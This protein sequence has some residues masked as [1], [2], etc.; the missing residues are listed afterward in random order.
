MLAVVLTQR[1]QV[2]TERGFEGSD[3]ETEILEGDG[4]AGLCLL[5]DCPRLRIESH[6]GRVA[7][8]DA[9]LDLLLEGV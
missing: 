7:A 4:V 1:Q 5:D 3:V 8:L 2:G 6:V 9:D